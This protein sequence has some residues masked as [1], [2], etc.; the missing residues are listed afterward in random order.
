M[1]VVPLRPTASQ[2]YDQ[3]IKDIE[4]S[5]KEF[6]DNYV[7]TS[8]ENKTSF[9][10]LQKQ[11]PQD[12]GYWAP[13]EQPATS[14]FTEQNYLDWIAKW[15]EYMAQHPDYITKTRFGTDQTG[16]FD[17]Y[18]YT[19]TPVNYE[20]T[21][22]V[23][24]CLHGNEK[25]GTYALYRF[26]NHLLNDWAKY[27]QLAYIRNKV[28]LIL[29]PVANPYGYQN[30]TRRNGNPIV[31]GSN[32]AIGIDLNRNFDTYWDNYTDL[33]YP[34]GTASFSEAE[35]TAIKALIEQYKDSIVF[36]DLHT[37]TTNNAQYICY[38]PRHEDG[39]F[40]EFRKYIEYRYN[41]DKTDFSFADGTQIV[42]FATAQLPSAIC[43]AGII[44]GMN[45]ATL[46]YRNQL[47]DSTWGSPTEVRKALE[48]YG[49][50]II[51]A[52]KWKY[53]PQYEV[54]T[55]PFTR[56]Y[57][58]DTSDV[59]DEKRV[60]GIS[61]YDVLDESEDKFEIMNPGIAM[62]EGYAVVRAE[63]DA[64][65]DIQLQLHQNYSPDFT[66]AKTTD[67]ANNRIK[68]K[69]TGGAYTIV[70]LMSAIKVYSTCRN[71]TDSSGN[72]RKP[73]QLVIRIRVRRT[74]ANGETTSVP[75]LYVSSYHLKLTYLP[76]DRG[77]CF[78]WLDS[79][80]YMDGTTKITPTAPRKI[81]P[82]TY[83]DTSND[84]EG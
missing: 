68:L 8:Q 47:F 57:T 82:I 73:Q 12:Y 35:T 3:R 23:E 84:D 63:T 9:E 1:A 19:L 80:P 72:P 29:I 49:N 45:S 50:M 24:A 32:G 60:T 78:T 21:M 20:K 26:I 71:L 67:V 77:Q 81:Y 48:W 17:M 40:S 30:D 31:M 27:P 62:A 6:E 66:S 5:V 34:K 39:S 14:T 75:A 74:G 7:E 37:I 42:D 2:S 51:L 65:A 64:I 15:D 55:E 10:N 76:S 36:L 58:F 46:E 28:R 16:V 25:M 79:S 69:L 44:Q 83:V 18:Y 13:P 52:S 56:L 54:L 53:K 11:N 59:A 41:K 70:P 43:H 4:N 22:I 33:G 38:M 61:I